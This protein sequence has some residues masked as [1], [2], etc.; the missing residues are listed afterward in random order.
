LRESLAVGIVRAVHGV[1]GEISV[2]SFS[3]NVSHLAGLR[4]AMA[5]KG[6]EEKRL[7]IERA[8]P[9]SGSVLMK[10]QG[11]D[12]PEKARELIGYELWVSRRH[13]APLDEGEYYEADLCRCRVFFG[14]EMIGAV[15]SIMDAGSSQLLEVT[16]AD[17]KDRLIPFIDHFVGEVDVKNGRISLREDYIIR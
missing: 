2:R 10:I 1:R 9:S 15:R 11:I 8:R 13:A 4:E 6:T 7:S 5:R 17:G 3:G 16:G 14:N 12:S